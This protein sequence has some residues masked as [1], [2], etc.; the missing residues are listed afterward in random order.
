MAAAGRDLLLVSLT[1][2]FSQRAHMTKVLPYITC[3][4]QVSLRLIDWFVTNYAKKHNTIIVASQHH[5]NV[6]LSY[7]AQLKAYSKQQFDPFR[8]RDRILFYHERDQH[9]ETTIGQLNFFRWMMLNGVLEH[10]AEHAETIE[11]DML[12]SHKA[13]PP[14][15]PCAPV[16]G[17]KSSPK[18][19]AGT[20]R[21]KR[22]ELS[23]CRA[24]QNLTCMAGKQMV[25]FD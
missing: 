21:K 24:T 23:R 18:D 22:A 15:P 16:A 14:P 19:T 7:R 17:K 2:F 10:V 9:V 1:R 3:A 6:F 4:S 20:P 11:A 5:F 25:Q 12:A 8:R 13:P